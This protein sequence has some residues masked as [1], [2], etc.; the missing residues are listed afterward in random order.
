LL[1]IEEVTERDNNYVITT[2]QLAQAIERSAGTAQVYGSTLERTIGY[3]T[4]IG[5]V[6]RESGKVIGNS[7]KS[8]MSR[9]SSV[10]EAVESLEGIG[11]AVKD[12]AGEMR[13]FDDIIDDLGAQW[14]DLSKEQ[15]QNLG[16]S[17]AGRYQLSRF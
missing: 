14:G 7:L 6:T 12:S 11:V 5:E 15:Q 4:A 16:V 8:V 10:P 1:R 17:I 9:I 3:T 13:E 2:Q